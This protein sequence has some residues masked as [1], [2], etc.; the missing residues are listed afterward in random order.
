MASN[1]GSAEAS[2]CFAL[3]WS[4]SGVSAAASSAAPACRAG[5]ELGSSPL[6]SLENG[7]P[8]FGAAC[9]R[10]FR[11]LSSQRQLKFAVHGATL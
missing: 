4:G 9:C 8:V 5:A 11:Y 2:R 3:D 10:V 6:H 1:T 7:K